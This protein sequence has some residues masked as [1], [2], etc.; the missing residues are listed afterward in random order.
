M[1]QFISNSLRSL[2]TGLLISIAFVVFGLSQS[3]MA[4]KYP[5]PGLFQGTRTAI[6]RVGFS[7][8]IVAPSAEYETIKNMHILERPYRPFHFYGNTIRRRHYRQQQL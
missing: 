2:R 3:A 6:A 7:P 4:G 5:V 1:P 8:N